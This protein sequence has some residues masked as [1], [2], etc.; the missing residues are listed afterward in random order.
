MVKKRFHIQY[1]FHVSWLLSS[2]WVQL[3][4]TFWINKQGHYVTCSKFAIDCFH[5]E[6][7]GL[8]IKSNFHFHNRLGYFLTVFAVGPYLLKCLLQN[9]LFFDLPRIEFHYIWTYFIHTKTLLCRSRQHT[10][11]IFN[12]NVINHIPNISQ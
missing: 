4:I 10:Y 1:V 9:N 11:Y 8:H 6:V 3:D 2:Y 12:I 7:Y 5:L